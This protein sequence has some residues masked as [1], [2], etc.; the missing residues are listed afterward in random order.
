MNKEIDPSKNVLS[1]VNGETAITA[2][3]SSTLSATVKKA[4][5][6]PYPI[7]VFF[8]MAS[9]TAERFASYVIY[10]MLTF[11]LRDRYGM[12]DSMAKFFLHGYICLC[13]LTPIAGSVLSDGWFGPYKVV[14]YSSVG[15]TLG[16]A[17]MTVGAVVSSGG[18]ADQILK[19]AGLSGLTLMGMASG[20]RKPCSA[21]FAANQF[22]DDMVHERAHFFSYF[23]LAMSVGMVASQLAT[24]NLRASLGCMGQDTCYPLAL[25]AGTVAMALSTFVIL[26]GTSHYTKNFQKCNVI[27]KTVQCVVFSMKKSMVA[28]KKQSKVIHTSPYHNPNI[29]EPQMPAKWLRCAIPKYGLD[30]VQ[31]VER[32]VDIGILFVPAI[33]YWS[34]YD[35]MFSAWMIQTDNMDG[36]LG[37]LNI[38]PDQLTMAF[39]L[40]VMIMIPVM[41]YVIYPFFDRWRILST[42]LRKMGLGFLLAAASFTLAG[43]LQLEID[44]DS[45]SISIPKATSN[46]SLEQHSTNNSIFTESFQEE[47]KFSIIWND[48]RKTETVH[49]LVT[50]R[51]KIGYV[52]DDNLTSIAS[53]F[54]KGPDQHAEHHLLKLP[55]YS[56]KFFDV[57]F[58][59]C[60]MEGPCL[61]RDLGL[62]S[63]ENGAS[64]ALLLDQTGRLWVVSLLPSHK[65]HLLWQLPQYFLMATS[66]ATFGVAGME[67]AYSQAS[68]SMKSVMQAVYLVACMFGNILAMIT[69]G[70]KLFPNAAVE[71]FVYASFML[72]LITFF[73][74]FAGRYTYKEE[75]EVEE[76]LGSAAMAKN[77]NDKIGESCF[78]VNFE[79]DE[80]EDESKT[81]SL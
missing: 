50:E 22:P 20:A 25:G 29:K 5:N 74:S 63:A 28:E 32:V 55:V 70:T 27:L 51:A 7:S 48:D 44:K 37:Y 34:L 12:D 45:S 71:F 21:A 56:H 40:M 26:A 67:F 46:N 73:L 66:E 15:C 49:F 13:Y 60:P 65:V 54:V 33:G 79:D 81:Y 11:F 8:C 9:E 77:G 4:R 58:R 19:I 18:V 53:I 42:P 16:L 3:A 61:N 38:P 64:D 6:R 36:R 10:T 35:Q 41:D 59:A 24:P 1:T 80:E 75:D 30:F 47:Q 69:S 68:A 39:S 2:A 43:V 17:L 31:R 72:I 23:Y 76:A 52:R 14:V 57:R 62:Y 78:D